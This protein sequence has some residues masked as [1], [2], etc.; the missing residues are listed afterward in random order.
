MKLLTNGLKWLTVVALVVAMPTVPSLAYHKAAPGTK[1]TPAKD[2]VVNV[3]SVP[4]NIPDLTP[5]HKFDPPRS[6]LFD[7][8][9]LYITGDMRVRPEFRTNS[10]FGGKISG[11]QI[12]VGKANDFF[13]TQM[14]RFGFDYEISPDLGFFFQPQ[15]AKVWGALSGTGSATDPGNSDDIG[16][17]G[18]GNNASDSLFVRQAFMLIR[19]AGMQNLSLKAGRQLIVF[20]NHRLFGHFDWAQVGF[21]FDGFTFNYSA[22]GWNTVGGWLRVA[23]GGHGAAASAPGFSSATTGTNASDDA[24]IFFIYNTL[25]PMKGLSVEPYW[26]YLINGGASAGT[27]AGVTTA[28]AANQNRHILGMRAAWR[29]GSTQGM[30]V[31]GTF[32]PIWQTGSMGVLGGNSDRSLRINAFGV[33]ALTGVTMGNVP[34]DPR[35]GFEFNYA[36]GDGDATTCTS[37]TT[38][39]GNANTFENLFPTNH[40]QYGYMDLQ[41]FRNTVQYHA[42]LQ[43]RPDPKSHV[44]VGFHI[45]RLAEAEDN[46]YR[47]SQGVYIASFKGNQ[48]ASLGRELDLVYTR[49]FKNNK[50]GWQLGYSHFW[51]GEFLG[52][53]GNR[54]T[55]GSVTGQDWGYS[56]LWINF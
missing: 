40:I 37:Q 12:D 2:R 23:E 5:Y 32:E 31:D 25:K 34:M 46:W 14:V 41:S 53:A 43:F 44:E 27:A 54:G 9:K 26:I 47:A 3:P 45:M 16:A 56:S 21:A 8:N 48:K 28:R 6:P 42:N 11:A 15:Y 22:K 49:F 19:N 24:D 35:I 36:S 33:H 4:R 38:C 1:T 39:G 18:A 7:I 13:A 10:G 51:A 50:V 17:G 29:L 55:V 52:Q 20:G 30:M